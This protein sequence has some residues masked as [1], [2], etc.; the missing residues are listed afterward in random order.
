[1]SL[2]HSNLQCRVSGETGHVARFRGVSGLGFRGGLVS[3]FG[4]RNASDIRLTHRLHNGSVFVVYT[5]DPIRLSRK[6]TIWDFPKI[7]VGVLRIR[8]LLFRVPY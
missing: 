5:S 1:M 2:S 7:R 3:L 4:L 8:I 6:G